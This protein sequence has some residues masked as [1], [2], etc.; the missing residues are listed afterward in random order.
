MDG[1]D[2]I[3]AISTPPGEGGIGI[4]RLSGPDALRI[5]SEIFIPA[6]G[7]RPAKVKSR[8]MLYGLIADPKTGA[9]IDEVLMT[10]MPA[11]NTYTRE[12]MAE[13][14][15]HG[16]ALPLRKT[17]ELVLR[18]GARLALP[19][20]F[21]K[22]AFLNG[23]IDLTQA[24]AVLELIRA[25]SDMAEKAALAQLKG[26]LG[27]RIKGLSDRLAGLRA[28]LEATIDFPEEDIETGAGAEFAD[29]I[30]DIREA[31]N[32]LSRTFEEGR[33][34]RDGVKTA[35]LGKPNVGKSSLLNALLGVSRAIVTPI[36]GTTRDVISEY[37]NLG[38]HALKIMDTA[39]IRKGRDRP[40]L[41]GVKRSLEALDEA[42]LVL[43]VLDGSSGLEKED[44][45]V[46]ER[47][48]AGW[49]RCILVINKTDLPRAWPASSVSGR[50]SEPSGAAERDAAGAVPVSAKTGQGIDGLK[51]KITA[52]F[53]DGLGPA[54]SGPVIT[55]IRHASALEGAA[56]AL[57]RALEAMRAGMPPEIV[58]IELA[59]ALHELGAITG[60]VSAED[61]LARI[62]EEFCIGK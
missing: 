1:R 42:D 46:M 18:A 23:R 61:I 26:E 58:S 19:G 59:D 34:L 52:G 6:K 37:M 30:E 10:V 13:I 3:A 29:R 44:F 39:G 48:K 45:E 31:V 43:C 20:E 11:P 54:E 9:G 32:A 16:G 57:G 35:I 51:E 2:T 53:R 4:V 55:S 7:K 49:K 5:S 17:L 41:E 14:N 50:L 21:T 33:L 8:R 38:G 12:D 56:G 27:G 40:E 22:R 62:F 24:E 28:H 60:Q 36:P 15:C 25:K 47:I